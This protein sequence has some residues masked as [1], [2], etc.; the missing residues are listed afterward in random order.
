MSRSLIEVKIFLSLYLEKL[1]YAAAVLLPRTNSSKIC[2]LCTN[3]KLIV[4]WNALSIDRMRAKQCWSWGSPIFVNL[5]IAKKPDDVSIW[6]FEISRTT[7]L[8]GIQVRGSIT[9]LE[10]CAHL[11]TYAGITSNNIKNAV[12]C[13]EMDFVYAYSEYALNRWCN[14]PRNTVRKCQVLWTYLRLIW[15]YSDEKK[16]IQIYDDCCRLFNG[17]ACN[18]QWVSVLSLGGHSTACTKRMWR[19]REPFV[20]STGANF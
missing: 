14:Y 11:Y 8:C 7:H 9:C 1:S 17:V 20:L 5:T 19:K 16:G 15:N 18:G 12:H 3:V 4:I 6:N 2:C 10:L 13:R